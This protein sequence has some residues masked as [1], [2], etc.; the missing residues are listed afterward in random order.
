MLF[1]ILIEFIEFSEYILILLPHKG[2]FVAMKK[3]LIF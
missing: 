3:K 2:S 1:F